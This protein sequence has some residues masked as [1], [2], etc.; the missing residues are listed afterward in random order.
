M[1]SSVMAMENGS[2]ARAD[3]IELSDYVYQRTR[4]RLAGLTDDEYSGSRYPAAVRSAEQSPVTIV[5]MT[6]TGPAPR[7]SRLSPGGCGT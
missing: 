6:R 4:S 5:L 3:I 7:P 1:R 2:D